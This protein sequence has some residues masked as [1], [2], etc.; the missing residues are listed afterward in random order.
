MIKRSIVLIGLALLATGCA[1][2]AAYEPYI[3]VDRIH[4]RGTG[5]ATDI[6]KESSLV[7]PEISG[8]FP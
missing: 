5:P 2:Q 1:E 3:I 6:T 4:N 8:V 7:K